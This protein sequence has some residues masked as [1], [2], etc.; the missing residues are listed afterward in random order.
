VTHP[1]RATRGSAILTLAYIVFTVLGCGYVAVAVLL[2]HLGDLGHG[3]HGGDAGHGD[4]G[5]GDAGH[6]H[7]HHDGRVDYGVAGEGHGVAAVGAHEGPQFHFPFFSPL[8][9]ATLFGSLG[10]YGLIAQFGLHLADTASLLAAIPAAGVTSYVVTYAAWRLVA[11]S[12]GSSQIR[13]A[14]LHGAPAEVTTPIPAGGIGEVAAMVSGQRYSGPAREVDGRE[15]PRGAR[16][17]V[18][19][20]MG[21]TLIVSWS[22]AGGKEG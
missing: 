15:V 7:G 2:G 4:A 18:K 8:A 6:D 10:A 20:L 17:T 13:L 19:A 3:D 22:G 5:H 14:D 16:V 12:V 21:T 1:S 11:G 9:L